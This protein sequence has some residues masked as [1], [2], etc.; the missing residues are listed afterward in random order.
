MWPILSWSVHILQVNTFS[1]TWA[2]FE[3]HVLKK[4]KSHSRSLDIW[5]LSIYFQ[6]MYHWLAL[7]ASNRKGAKIQPDISWFC[8][9]LFFLKHQNNVIFVINSEEFS[10][11]FP[12]LRYLCTMQPHWPHQRQK[13]QWP[14]QPFFCLDMSK[15]PRCAA[16]FFKTRRSILV[17]HLG[18]QSVSYQDGTPCN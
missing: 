18:L 6:K 14:Q 7:T 15:P 17:G 3:L 11:D 5:V 12:G 8:Q 13:P 1:S 9:Q 16:T 2:Q 4:V 10:G